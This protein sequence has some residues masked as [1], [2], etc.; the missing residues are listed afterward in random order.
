MSESTTE[1]GFDTILS[2]LEEECGFQANCYERS[3]LKR[4]IRAR[5]RRTEPEDY[6]A[7]HE[8]L[9]DDP[10]ERVELVD[11]LSINVTKF[12]RNPE[13]WTALQP[14]LRKRYDE[15]GSVSCWSAACA[16][17][18]EPYSMAIMAAEDPTIDQSSVDILATDIDPN[19]LDAASRGRYQSTRTHDIAEELD[20][21]SSVDSYFSN[22]EGTYEIESTIKSMVSFEQH[23]LVGQNPPG[24]FDIVMCRNLLI[25]I[26]SEAKRAIFDT[27]IGSLNPGGYLVIGMSET[28]PR[29]LFEVVEPV[30]RSRRIYRRI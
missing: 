11:A 15:R 4:R 13:V 17:G 28:I 14:Y 25:Y 3:Y 1:S 6:T 9:V 26:E 10:D 2:F 19:A 21:L 30:D 8:L 23:D 5:L 12:F 24:S 27:L 18:R 22:E 29:D 16:D 20:W 7:Y